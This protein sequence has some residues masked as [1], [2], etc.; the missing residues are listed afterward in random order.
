MPAE[1]IA[2][3]YSA[4]SIGHYYLAKDEVVRGKDG[5]EYTIAEGW[6][7]VVGAISID[8]DEL[9]QA[10]VV[11]EATSDDGVRVHVPRKMGLLE[12]AEGVEAESVE[13]GK[14]YQPIFE[15]AV[16]R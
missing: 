1:D 14:E 11:F 7:S 9:R 12:L 8:G 4:E 10:G 16:E 2:R 5:V 13:I 15:A 3:G 6:H